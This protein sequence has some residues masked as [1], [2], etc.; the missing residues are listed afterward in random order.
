MA[1][2]RAA[3]ASGATRKPASAAAK[4]TPLKRVLRGFL[5]L[6]IA[7]VLGSLLL[8]LLL[9]W[10]NP[11]TSAIRLLRSA[12][13]IHA[14]KNWQP[15]SCWMTLA[16]LG[17][18]VPLAVIAT[19]DQRFSTHHG[20]DFEEISQAMEEPG[21][22]RGASTLS[23]QLSKNLFLWP[24]RNWL[25][26]GLEVYFTMAIETLWSKRRILEMYLNIVEFGDQR[27]GACAGARAAFARDP[28]RLSPYQ[29]ALLA[30]SLPNPHKR[31]AAQPSREMHQRA[32]WAIQ[33]MQ[34]LGGA[35]YLAEL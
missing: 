6:V 13:A 30:S 20:F 5:W 9:R 31:N 18:N 27:F 21:R 15:Q 17:P 14:G 24:G 11:P 33:Q 1:K 34:Q 8:V 10:I 22:R 2:A 29:A 7:S 32:S 25:R 12:Q 4:R 26:K 3:K 23:Q 19:E 35:R 16:Q 28:A